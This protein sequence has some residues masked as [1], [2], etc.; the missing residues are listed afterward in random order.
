MGL[1]LCVASRAS[2]DNSDV[3][4]LRGIL[5]AASETLVLGKKARYSCEMALFLESWV[6]FSSTTRRSA[7]GLSA[8]E[9]SAVEERRATRMPEEELLTS[10]HPPEAAMDSN[11]QDVPRLPLCGKE[12]QFPPSCVV[13]GEVCGE[14]LS[15]ASS[16]K[17]YSIS[18]FFVG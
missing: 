1:P 2:A 9:Y 8:S 18:P 6:T 13:Y 10:D 11:A 16:A 5:R 15:C 7:D 14:V 17:S 3:Q 12:V 4:I